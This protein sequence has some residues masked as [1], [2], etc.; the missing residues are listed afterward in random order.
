[1]LSKVIYIIVDENGQAITEYGLIIVLI[2]LIAF[3][4]IAAFFPNYLT[5]LYGNINNNVP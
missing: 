1:M 4:V 3:V 2:V 5:N